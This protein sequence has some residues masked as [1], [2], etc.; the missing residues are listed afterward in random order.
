MTDL[1]TSDDAA[2]REVDLRALQA[3]LQARWWLLVAGLVI[4]A[5]I[6]I[7]L[8]AGSGQ[9][10][11]AKTLLYLGQPFTTSGGGQIQSLA[12]NPRTVSEIV[13]S[14][15]ALR[16]AAAASGVRLGQLRG[17]VASAAVVS[18]TQSKAT[19]PLVDITVEGAAR[20]KV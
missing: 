6:G 16:R 1:V 11:R 18:A 2:E 13:H 17:H 19:S 20:L 5:I 15:F 10:W 9:T 8:A 7:L 4:G 14:E 12:T 3:R